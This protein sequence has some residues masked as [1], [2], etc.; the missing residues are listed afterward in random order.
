MQVLPAINA[1]RFWYI[2]VYMYIYTAFTSTRNYSR[3]RNKQSDFLIII[4]TGGCNFNSTLYSA[5]VRG[6]C[7]ISTIM[8]TTCIGFYVYK[9]Y[10]NTILNKI[11]YVYVQQGNALRIYINRIVGRVPA[12][13]NPIS[14]EIEAFV[15]TRFATDGVIKALY[16]HYYCTHDTRVESAALAARFADLSE[17]YTRIYSGD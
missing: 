9:I 3:A 4:F 12:R 1:M 6:D 13:L 5:R 14:T 16:T 8:F 17:E 2:R 15:Y 10:Y 7:A 11:I